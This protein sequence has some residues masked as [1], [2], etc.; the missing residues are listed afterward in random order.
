M[1]FSEIANRL[2]G[3]STPVGGVS[4]QPA[5]L[6]IAGARRVVAFLEDRRVLYDPYQMELVS[7]SHIPDGL[8]AAMTLLSEKPRQGVPSWNPAPIQGITEANCTTA[9][10]LRFGSRGILSG[11][12]DAP[13]IGSRINS[14]LQCGSKTANQFSIAGV[15]GINEET[16]PIGAALSNAFLG[17]TFSGIS[18][19]V[20]HVA[21]GHLGAAY[22]DFALG[23]TAQ[24]LP[25]GTVAA[26]KGIVGVVTEGA[27]GAA[28]GE[29]MATPVG[30]VKLA[31]DG[32]TYLGSLA[33][34]SAH[35]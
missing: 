22:A 27:L 35:P 19:T 25:I 32:A 6:E 28:V 10:G 29:E 9:I 21:T 2:T 30:W 18:D 5:E 7:G 12:V 4:W 17:N 15:L 3:I 1:K 11:T 31:I 8:L 34:C 24:G 33:Y 13:S 23:G 14:V 26:S 20:T 16:H